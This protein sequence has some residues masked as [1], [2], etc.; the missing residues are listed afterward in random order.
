MRYC[1]IDEISYSDMEKLN[2]FL[3]QH[4]MSSD[5]EKLFWIQIPKDLLNDIQFQHVECSPHVFAVE[6]GTDWIRMEF[7]IRNLRN[8]QCSCQGYC[9][10]L[11]RN[12]VLNF[13]QKTIEDL[14]FRT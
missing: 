13:A 11:Q 4:A 1:L 7:F 6:L 12:F 9:T 3:K 10:S 8:L 5:L 2:K 14:G